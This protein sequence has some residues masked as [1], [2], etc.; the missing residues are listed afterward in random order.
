M[1][2]RVL[3]AARR[4][5]AIQ[6]AIFSLSVETPR[7]GANLALVALILLAP[8]LMGCGK[9]NAPTPPPGVPITYPRPY[10]RE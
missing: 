4:V 1:R 6:P 8:T 5:R 2:E 3:S 7:A 10:P 9:K